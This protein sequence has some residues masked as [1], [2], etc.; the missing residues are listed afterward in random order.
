MERWVYK[1]FSSKSTYTHAHKYYVNTLIKKIKVCPT[2]GIKV[3]ET[4][5][6]PLNDDSSNACN[7]VSP[8]NIIKV[9][10]RVR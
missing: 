9:L 7:G 1:G 6:Q 3:C 10:V 4:A 8:F 5:L 2:I